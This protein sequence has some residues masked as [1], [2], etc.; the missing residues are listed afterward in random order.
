MADEILP[1]SVGLGNYPQRFA[2]MGDGTWAEKVL[3]AVAVGGAQVSASNPLPVV[4]A[5]GGTSLADQSVVDAAGTFWLVRDNGAT[6]S[7]LNWA[8]GASGTPV[9]PVAP[10]GKLTGEQVISTQYNAIAAGTGFASGDVLSHIVILNIATSPASVLA[11]TWANIT[12]GTVLT[13]SPTASSLA[14]ITASVAVSALPALPAGTNAIGS[15]AVTGLPALPAGSNAIGTVGLTGT[16]PGFAAAPTVNVGTLPAL[17][18]GANLIGSVNLDIGGAAI[19]ASNPVPVLDAYTAPSTTTWSSVTAAN[20]AATFPTS[21]Y[22]TVIVTLAA[23]SGFAGGVVAFEV[24]DGASWMPIKAANIANYTSA[25]STLAPSANTTT[26]YQLA[27]AG[28][29]QMRVRLTNAPT[30]GT[31][32]VTAIVSSAPDVSLVT[33]GL[34]PAQPLP[35]GS[36]ALGS[37]VVSSLPALPAGSNAIGAVTLNG[38][39]P[40]FASPPAVNIGTM[41]ALPA[42]SNLIGAVNLDVGGATIS[43]SNPLPVLD[44][45]LAPSATSWTTATAANTAATFAT[46]G[47]DTVIVTLVASSTFA[48]GIAVFEVYDGASW[49]AVK[50]SN[51]AN[52]TT[53]GATIVPTA[54]STNGY[55]I[56]VAGF[57]QFRVRLASA[58]T[59][60]TL[61]VTAIISSAPDVS[62]VTVGLDPSQPLPAGSNLLGSVGISSMPS[63]PAGAN[64]IGA[65]TL[66]G[67][68]PALSAGTNTIGSV[69]TDGVSDASVIGP[70]SVTS[71]TTI[72]S[73]ATQGYGGGIFNLSAAGTSCIIVFQQ[74]WDN[75]NWNSLETWSPTNTN[76][77]LTSSTG[78]G[79]AYAFNAS[80][81]YV[82]AAV[83]T[84]GSGTV[85]CSLTLKRAA[86]WSPTFVMPGSNSIGTVTLNAGTNLIGYAG[87]G[88]VA[89]NANA[90]SVA[91]I[92][93]PAT[94]AGA[95]IKASAGRV[96]GIVLNNSASALR[97]VKFFNATSVTMGTTAAAFELD[98]PA[99]GMVSLTPDGGIGFATGVMWAVTGAKGLTDNTTA[100]L[101]AN[102]VSGVVLYA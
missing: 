3:A 59:A 79:G 32:L 88:Y 14:E 35:A 44:A 50:A 11:S 24:Y 92:L 75:V 56:P 76:N 62:V 60:G 85:T 100:G 10:A 27:V 95:T 74:S 17:A 69:T 51:V 53:T 101:A 13:A 78:S 63:I 43:A 102:D 89:G 82:R 68:L 98:I 46:N 16:L 77:P 90:A 26:G 42:G 2:D 47:Y 37:I 58:L 28:F 96:V 73:A 54:N 15:V 81:P 18:A 91:S 48:G 30:A 21:G 45:Y 72:V 39:L 64:T 87:L 23:S 65:V 6:L 5:S 41:P 8:T 33:V 7:Y 36:N 99:G 40:A 4:F 70:A 97:S 94:P 9:A 66:T 93:S 29:P 12:Q 22:D 34:D 52:Y 84:Y 31:L 19:S 67:T 55:Q 57:P 61:L 71:A 86:Q 80:A 83:N 25:G 20:T 1:N 49:M 38:S